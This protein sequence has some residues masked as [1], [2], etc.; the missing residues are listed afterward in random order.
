MWLDAVSGDAAASLVPDL[1]HIAL[2]QHFL[3]TNVGAADAFG[4]RFAAY[5]LAASPRLSGHQ[6]VQQHRCAAGQEA[7]LAMAC[8]T[9]TTH[10]R[11]AP[12]EAAACRSA[13][14]DQVAHEFER[15]LWLH[16]PPNSSDIS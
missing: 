13:G 16:R 6:A 12:A 14:A 1:M 8:W 5:W 9:D 2:R 4:D 3:L 7:M 11:R 10:Q 15:A